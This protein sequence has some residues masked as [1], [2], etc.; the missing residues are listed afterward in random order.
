MEF[1]NNELIHK[2]EINRLKEQFDKGKPYKHLVIKGLLKEGKAREVLDAL[3]KEKFEYKE[4]DLFS[5]K[6]TDDLKFTK[7]NSLKE[8]YNFFSSEEFVNW[9]GKIIH[10]KW[11][12]IVHYFI[13]TT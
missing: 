8:L 9:I 13:K 3:I 1:I 4:S 6:Q 10:I 5:L 2:E 12:I 11:F 7:N